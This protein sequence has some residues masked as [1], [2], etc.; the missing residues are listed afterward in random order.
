MAK[1]SWFDEHV[2]IL[3]PTPELE[4]KVKAALK[5][6]VAAEFGAGLVEDDETPKTEG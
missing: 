1:K 6:K 4:E 5:E 3:G 2:V